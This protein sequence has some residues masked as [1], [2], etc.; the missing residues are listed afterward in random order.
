VTSR[1]SRR[2]SWKT[3][4]PALRQLRR[5]PLTNPSP[6]FQRCT[7]LPSL[8]AKA[9]VRRFEHA[10]DVR[11]SGLF[12]GPVRTSRRSRCGCRSTMTRVVG[13]ALALFRLGRPPDLWIVG[14]SQVSRWLS[15]LYEV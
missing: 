1:R 12:V 11:V 13:D 14:A 6:C 15:W 5:G 4:T 3:E 9:W 8:V 10:G 7:R 2:I